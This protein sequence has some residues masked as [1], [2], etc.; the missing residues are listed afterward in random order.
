LLLL[1]KG[2]P[3]ILL[4]NCSSTVGLDGVIV[5]LDEDIRERISRIQESWASRGQRVILLARKIIKSGSSEIP[6]GMGPDHA[7][8][9]NTVMK[10]V[11]TGLTFIGLVGIV[12]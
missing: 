10:I 1:I 2:A 12:V 6:A 5:P 3:D 9:G 4:P 11:E 8:F 7:L